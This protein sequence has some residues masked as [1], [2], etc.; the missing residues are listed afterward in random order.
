[1]HSDKAQD[2]AVTP[3]AHTDFFCFAI[4]MFGTAVVEWQ[5]NQAS[6]SYVSGPTTCETHRHTRNE[7]TAS[8]LQSTTW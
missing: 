4:C 2:V 8:A 7:K 6:F 3:D 1:M 5:Q